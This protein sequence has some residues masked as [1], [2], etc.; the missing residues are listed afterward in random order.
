MSKK[1]FSQEQK[2]KI[3]ES[4]KKFQKTIELF[5]YEF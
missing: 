5:G 3:L 1:Q 2:L 4:A